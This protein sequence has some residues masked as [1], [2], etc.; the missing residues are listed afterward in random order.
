[1]GSR[2]RGVKARM[3][4]DGARGHRGAFRLLYS[5]V[6][7][8][9]ISAAPRRSKR[10]FCALV[11]VVELKAAD[12]TA[13]VFRCKLCHS[14]RPHYENHV[15]RGHLLRRAFRQRGTFSDPIVI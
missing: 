1:M 14:Q 10:L 2:I 8:R 5:Y 4:S 3:Q 11:K 7:L 15:A 12:A 6:Q 13:I 9:S